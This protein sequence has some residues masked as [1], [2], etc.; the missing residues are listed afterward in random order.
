MSALL[1][2][3]CQHVS[4]RH[5]AVGMANSASKFCIAKGGGREAKKDESGGGYALC[6]LPDSRIVEE[7]EYFRSQH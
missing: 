4:D 1:L 3:A 7:W 5:E 6:H 2:T